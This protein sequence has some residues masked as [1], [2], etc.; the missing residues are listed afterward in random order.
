MNTKRWMTLF[1]SLFVMLCVQAQEEVTVK[2]FE[3][4]MM[5]ISGKK[6]VVKD[7]NEVPC[8][9]IKVQYPKEGATFSGDVLGTPELKQGAYWVYVLNGAKRISIHLPETPTLEVE[10]RE[11]GIT[12]VESLH[13]YTLE[14]KFPKQGMPLEFYAEAGFRAG[15]MMGAELALGTYLGN[16]NLEVN[17]MLPVGSKADVYW[18]RNNEA[19]SVKCSYKPSYVVGGRLGY[20]IMLGEKLRLTPQAGVMF[21]KMSES[22]SGGAASHYG[23]AYCGSLA[24]ALKCQYLLSEHLA[25]GVCPEYDLPVVKSTGFDALS[26]ASG[27]I[28]KWNSGIGVKVSVTASF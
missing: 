7:I 18:Y 5:D 10:F 8:A 1:L 2:T 26:A 6:Y 4:L 20:G 12:K 23:G 21:M 15:G 9:L 14:L 22:V 3:E 28:K 27:K 16:F 13:T 25:V 24:V 17:A 11:Y 19:Q